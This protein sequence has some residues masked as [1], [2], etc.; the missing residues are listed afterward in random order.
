MFVKSTRRDL[1]NSAAMAVAASKLPVDLHP[2]L[3]RVSSLPFRQTNFDDDW[4]FSKGDI[5]G[6]HLS[7]F[8]DE[9]W[10]QG[11]RIRCYRQP[12]G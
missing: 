1:L 6:A 5:Q 3:E 8:S 10:S 4:K 11:L 9:N 2:E 7:H 12:A